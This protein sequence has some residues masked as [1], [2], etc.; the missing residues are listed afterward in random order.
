MGDVCCA[1]LDFIRSGE[2]HNRQKPK[3]IRDLYSLSKRLSPNNFTETLQQALK[4]KVDSIR[5]IQRIAQ[6]LL[7]MDLFDETENPVNSDYQNR[8]EYRKGR[9]SSEAD[10]KKYQDLLKNEGKTDE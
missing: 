3:L 6:N 9:L 4:F 5:S 1:Y 7:Q 10:L 2:C 8:E